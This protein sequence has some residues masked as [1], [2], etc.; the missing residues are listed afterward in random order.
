MPSPGLKTLAAQK[1]T[2]QPQNKKAG[3]YIG[4]NHNQ[5]GKFNQS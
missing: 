5:H 1:K 2:K 3:F 4:N